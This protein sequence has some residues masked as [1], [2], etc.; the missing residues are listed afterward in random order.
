MT[1]KKILRG[2]KVNNPFYK[3]ARKQGYCGRHVSAMIQPTKAG[4]L[5]GAIVRRHFVKTKKEVKRYENNICS[6]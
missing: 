6:T 3:N 2:R 4:K 5:S 1:L